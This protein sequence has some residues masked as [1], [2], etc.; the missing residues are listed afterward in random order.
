MHRIMMVIPVS[1][2]FSSLALGQTV[3]SSLADLVSADWTVSARGFE[4]LSR[5]PDVWQR[6]DVAA[7][8]LQA[9]DRAQ[10]TVAETFNRSGGK[11]G[12]SD[13]YGEEFGEHLNQLFTQCLKVCE[14]Q[15]LLSQMLRETTSGSILRRH[16]FELL[17]VYGVATFS[18]VQRARIDSAFVV[19]ARDPDWSV[20]DASLGGIGAFIRGDSAITPARRAFLRQAVVNAAADT[21]HQVRMTAVR[22][23]ADFGGPEDLALLR[24]MADSDPLQV[25]RRG[26]QVF[27]VR[28]TAAAELRRLEKR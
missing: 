1:A 8:L 11:L 20:R 21:Q 9:Y 14:R 12:V 25:M 4:R 7:G 26:R 15:A 5:M 28:E 17:G 18:A 27:P 16:T 19:G 23:L 13:V 2:L 6:S 22:R 24:Q 3:E 10:Q